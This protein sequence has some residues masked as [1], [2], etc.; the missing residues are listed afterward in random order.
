MT[1]LKKLV[2]GVVAAATLS[3]PYFVGE[4]V[5]DIKDGDT[6]TIGNGQLIRLYGLDAPEPLNCYGSE[7]TRRLSELILGKKIVLRE[8]IVDHFR[9]V[10]ALVYVDGKLVNEIMIREGFGHYDRAG[11]SESQALREANQFA[12]ANK[13]GIYGAEC[14]QPDPPDPKCVIKGNYDRDKYAWVYLRPDCPYY[15]K[16]II[17]KFKG[18]RYFCSESEAQAAGFTKAKFCK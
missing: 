17:E 7:A 9:R 2:V 18:E 3:L 15:N 5:K 11:Q 10:V 8:P 12:R 14:Y 1:G 13:L 4:N 16:T 6:F